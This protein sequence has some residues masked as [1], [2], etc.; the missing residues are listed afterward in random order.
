DFEKRFGR[1][2]SFASIQ[3][4]NSVRLL[5]EALKKTGGKAQGLP[6]ALVEVEGYSDFYAPRGLNEYG[7]VIAP[8]DILKVSEG[9]FTKV[10]IYDPGEG[11]WR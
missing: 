5:F 11:E 9:G 7:D 10:E 3:G 8:V 6:G 2:P 4:Y 1:K